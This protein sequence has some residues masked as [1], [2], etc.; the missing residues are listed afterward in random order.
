MRR[1]ILDQYGMNYLTLTTVD[2]TDVFTRKECR[3]VLID[4]LWDKNP[5][6]SS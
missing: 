4:S 5:L 2:W 1:K 6:H 3:E